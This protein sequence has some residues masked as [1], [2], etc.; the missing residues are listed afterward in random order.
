MPGGSSSAAPVPLL[1]PQAGLAVSS[2][3]GTSLGTSHITNPSS[4]CSPHLALLSH[5]PEGPGCPLPRPQP[6]PFTRCHHQVQSAKV[7]LFL[8]PLK[9]FKNRTKRTEKRISIIICKYINSVS[10]EPA[11]PRSPPRGP[12]RTL[13]GEAR[14]RQ[15]SPCPGQHESMESPGRAAVQGHPAWGSGSLLAPAGTAP[16]SALPTPSKPSLLPPTEVLAFL[17]SCEMFLVRLYCSTKRCKGCPRTAPS[18]TLVSRLR[19]L[20]A[21][22]GRRWTCYL[23]KRS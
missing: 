16:A 11:N 12:T 21:G 6:C 17:L 4:R 13:A 23:P 3:P 5:A 14:P 18:G 7:L 1:C 8:H 2:E 10:K 20:C 15:P 22:P 19:D 9:T